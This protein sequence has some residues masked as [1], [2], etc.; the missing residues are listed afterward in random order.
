MKKLMILLCLSIILFAGCD[1]LTPPQVE[2]EI[3]GTATSVNITYSNASEGTSQVSDVSVPWTYSFESTTG[4]FLYV[5]AQN[6]NDSGSLTATIYVDGDV[7]KTST[8]SGAYVI[9]TASGSA[10]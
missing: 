4:N 2:Y 9:A 7:Y 10:P 5:S 8:S 1:I 6:Q 3:S